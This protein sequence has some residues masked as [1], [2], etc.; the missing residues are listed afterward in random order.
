[1]I[2]GAVVATDQAT[3]QKAAR[4]VRVEYRPLPPVVTI[5]DAIKH[6]SYHPVLNTGISCGDVDAVFAT[7]APAD[8]V[9]GEMRTG[10]QEQFYLETQA[11]LAIPKGEHGEMV[12]WSSTQNP[13]LTQKVVAS[14]TGVDANRVNVHVKRMGGGFGGKESRS[15]PIAAVV[16]AAAKKTNKPVRIMLDRDEDMLVTGFRNP[17]Y[18]RYK[19]A[20]DKDGRIL[21]LD[22]DLYA[23]GG[24]TCDLTFSVV[25]RALFHSD[26]SYKVP[27]LRSRGYVCKTN[28]ASNTAFRG[29]GGPQ[30][31]MIAETWVERIAT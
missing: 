2:I 6:N 30:G 13:N 1:M 20:H 12:V 29:F 14:V 22:V 26:N 19:V 17:F 3:A 18:G 28:L 16:A 7:T 21:A 10:A 9:E 23:N 8:M 24:W 25:E 15:V 4:L 31:L 11:T 5:D 27:N